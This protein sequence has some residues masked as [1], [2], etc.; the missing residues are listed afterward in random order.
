MPPACLQ[1]SLQYLPHSPF[2]GTVQLHAGC[3][4]FVGWL[5]G[6]SWGFGPTHHY[7]SFPVRC[8]GAYKAARLSRRA[9]DGVWRRLSIALVTHADSDRAG[10]RGVRRAWCGVAVHRDYEWHDVLDVEL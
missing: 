6:S 10:Q 5:I 4:H 9:A 3:A 7:M 2:S 8:C 1:C